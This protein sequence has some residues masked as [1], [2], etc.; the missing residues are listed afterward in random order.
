MTSIIFT[1]PGKPTAWQ[2]AGLSTKQGRA[3]IYTKSES[4]SYQSL[5]REAA[6]AKWQ[7]EPS[8]GPFNLSV[9]VSVLRPKA[10]YLRG[11]LRPSAPDLCCRRPDLDNVAKQIGD[12]LNG[13]VW[14]DDAQINTLRVERIWS[15]IADRVEVIIEEIPCRARS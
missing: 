15:H 14:R 7:R 10:H 9:T 4:R 2:R 3:L 12:A 13:V 11:V 5:V 8:A 1:V 6:Q